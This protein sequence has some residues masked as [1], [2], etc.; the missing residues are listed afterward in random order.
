MT[1]PFADV[2]LSF[3]VAVGLHLP[4]VFDTG[5]TK[6]QVLAV[7]AS[8]EKGNLPVLAEAS[9]TGPDRGAAGH[10]GRREDRCGPNT[11]G[12]ERIQ[13]GAID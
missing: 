10:H 11:N 2:T 5:Q 13:D 3:A 12:R 8:C 4:A 7:I 6:V 9:R 1:R